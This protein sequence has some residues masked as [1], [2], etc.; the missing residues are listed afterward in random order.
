MGIEIKEELL[1]IEGIKRSNKPL[2]DLFIRRTSVLTSTK[3][4]LTEKIVKDQWKNAQKVTRGDTNVSE[5]D[6][7]NLGLFYLSTAK[8]RKKLEKTEKIFNETNY[9]DPHPDPKIDKHRQKQKKKY[10]EMMNVIKLKL[11]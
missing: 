7:C 5:F 6:F 11:K 10:E 1:D 8:A 3:E 2:L 4:S 9:Y